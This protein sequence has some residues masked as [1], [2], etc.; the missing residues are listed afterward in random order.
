MR[1]R[2]YAGLDADPSV[3]RRPANLVYGLDEVPPQLAT[4]LNAVQHVGLISINLVYPLLIFRAIDTPVA[5][6]TSALGIGMIVLGLATF[7]QVL[8]LGPFGSGYMCPASFT[9]AYVSP[10]LLAVKAGGLPLLFGMTMV[11]GIIEL[12]LARLLDRMRAIFPPEISGLV[13]FMI[14]VTGGIAGLRALVGPNAAP[15]VAEEWWVVLITLG[16]MAAVNVWGKGMARMLCALVGLAVGYAT[17]LLSGLVGPA[18]LAVLA[19]APWFALPD[20]GHVSWAFDAS[21]IA[22]FA[23]VAVAAAMKTVGTI[24]ICQRMNDADWVRPDMRSAI[25]GVLSDGASTVVA[26]MAGACGTN[27]STPS[28]GLAAATGVAS[29]RVAHAVGALF[30]LFGVAPKVAALLAVMPRA[31]MAAAL[32]FTVCFILVSGLQVMASRLMDA[33]KTIVIGLAIVG[34][35]GVEVFPLLVASAPQALAPLV[36]TALVCSTLIALLLNLL[37]RIGVRKRVTLSISQADIDPGRIDA[38]F[39][40]H[41]ARW[42]ARPEVIQ[43]AVFGIGQLVEAV[44]E[45]CWQAGP[46]EVEASFDEFSLDVVLAYRGALLEFPAVRPSERDIRDSDDGV[47]RLAGFLLRHNADRVGSELRDGRARVRFHFD[48]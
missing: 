10:S 28:V 3:V 16:T 38:F 15:V 19:E 6:V 46:L 21:L 35:T 4:V 24:A 25:R 11:A 40:D 12:A 39:R 30:I 2:C 41:G 20:F 37:F 22:P 42:G 27:T 23:I 8:R 14:G 34:G 5:V 48:H 26:G 1:V 7:L 13:I 33:R 29:R 18:E 32:V 47:R 44:A 43:R 17:A 36:G 31:V 9:A 45:N